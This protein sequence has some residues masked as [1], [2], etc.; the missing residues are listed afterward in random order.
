MHFGHHDRGWHLH[1]AAGLGPALRAP[2][3][4]LLGCQP[5]TLLSYLF[6]WITRL[7]P[8]PAPDRLRTCRHVHCLTAG[9]ACL[10]LLSEVFAYGC[11]ARWLKLCTLWPPFSLVQQPHLD[12]AEDEGSDR[13]LQHIKQLLRWLAACMLQ[14]SAQSCY[15][16]RCHRCRA[17]MH[18]AMC[19]TSQNMAARAAR[20][21]LA[22][23]EPAWHA[24]DC[25]HRDLWRP[26]PWAQ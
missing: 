24:G 6:F 15:D 20:N 23:P 1:G 4:H 8:S 13:D 11:G 21:H 22:L 9:Q 26:V 25:G 14:R 18:W 19:Q 2:E 16:I 10:W 17:C 7:S 3:D 12:F 5:G